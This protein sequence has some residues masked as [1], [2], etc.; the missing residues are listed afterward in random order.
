MAGSEFGNPPATDEIE[1]SLFGPGYGESVLLHL[2][3]QDWVI[4]DSCLNKDKAPAALS[5]LRSLGLN[6]S[7]VVKL[8]VATHWHDDHVGG[9]GTLFRECKNAE[10]V[11]SD[12]LR[13]DEFLTLVTSLKARPMMT[14]SGVKEFDEVLQVLKERSIARSKFASPTWALANRRIWA[15][16]SGK[17]TVP[18]EIYSLS[19]S[20]LSITLAKH[21]IAS[22]IPQAGQAK[23]R[24]SPRPPNHVAVVLWVR[25]SNSTILLG[26]DLED[27]KEP[28]TG[29]IAVLDSTSR[30]SD[31]A[32]V[33]K[34]AHHGSITAY[35]PR[36][37]SEML[38]SQAVATLTPFIRGRTILPTKADSKRICEHTA[39]SFST[40]DTRAREIRGRS[41]IVI[42]T[43]RETVRSIKE[44]PASSGV[45]RLR[46][47]VSDPAEADWAAKLFGT[48]LPLKNLC[49]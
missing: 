45:V 43:I 7:E 17:S 25:V 16:P 35:Q 2:G 24:V 44:V 13:N 26:S 34:V 36:V 28:S 33:F 39:K 14:S 18:A 20:D 31:R 37:W 40:A 12:A 23:R 15:R 49:A 5:Y 22:L 47:M 11:C 6:P 10:F 19:P 30:P 41:N 8:V 4:A 38:I 46:K 48:A 21:A 1:V 29:W 32:S 27:T 3:H 9:M 42:K